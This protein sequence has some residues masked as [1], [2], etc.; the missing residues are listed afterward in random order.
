MYTCSHPFGSSIPLFSTA[1]HPK[2]E[3]PPM[4]ALATH[5]VRSHYS[6]AIMQPIVKEQLLREHRRRQ[7]TERDAAGG[8]WQASSYLFTTP[9]GS[10][11]HPDW[12]TRRFRRLVT[13]SG[14]PPVRLHDLR[15][16]AASLA[17]AA[18]ADLKTVQA[19][20]GHASIVLTADTY[21]SVLPELLADSAEATARLVVAHAARKPN[22]LGFPSYRGDIALRGVTGG[23]GDT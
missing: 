12:L 14:L 3:R 21:T 23:G 22:R 18:G 5:T 7:Q 2:S 17:L 19:L 9:D 10:P 16:G 1:G 6:A 11:L 4:G 20:L 15:H 8:Q 13:L